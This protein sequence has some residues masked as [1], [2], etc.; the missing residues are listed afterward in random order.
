MEQN[1]NLKDVATIIG[2]TCAFLA[3]TFGIFRWE[4]Q[5]RVRIRIKPVVLFMVGNGGI[6]KAEKWNQQTIGWLGNSVPLRLS[7]EIVNHSAFAITICEVG[8][9][10]GGKRCVAMPRPELLPSNK[11]WPPRLEPKEAVIAMGAV[12]NLALDVNFIKKPFAYARTD[13]GKT[14]YGTSSIFRYIHTRLLKR[15]SRSP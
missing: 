4:L 3:L 13:C 10:K 12:D 14:F 5:R 6:M 1:S 7:V 8:F 2:A 15:T 11:T 9:G